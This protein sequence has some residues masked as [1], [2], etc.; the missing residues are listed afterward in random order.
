MRPNDESD[1]FTTPKPKYRKLAFKSITYFAVLLLTVSIFLCACKDNNIKIDYEDEYIKDGGAEAVIVD[2]LTAEYGFVFEFTSIWNDYMPGGGWAVT[3][4]G[5]RASI[6][7][8]HISSLNP[9]PSMKVF[10][11][12][13]TDTGR[14]D[15]VPFYDI[16]GGDCLNILYP[17]KYWRDYRPAVNLCVNGGYQMEI[18]VEIDGKAQMK[19]VRGTVGSTY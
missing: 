4:D 19:T 8:V 6:V 16:Y 12:I 5:L 9:L 2:D 13:I 15:N 10:A 17:G 11:N 3:A 7:V 1:G 14:F 18:T